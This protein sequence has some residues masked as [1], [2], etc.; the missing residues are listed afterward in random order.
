MLLKHGA[1][2]SWYE[3]EDGPDQTRHAA[4]GFH[5]KAVSKLVSTDILYAGD[6]VLPA[7]NGSQGLEN[8]GVAIA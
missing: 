1:L 5:M 8:T 4:R 7:C 3:P 6:G 2:Q